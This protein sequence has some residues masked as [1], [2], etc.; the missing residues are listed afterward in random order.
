MDVAHRRQCNRR[1]PV[2]SFLSDSNRLVLHRPAQEAREERL[3]KTIV[4]ET[5]KGNVLE[6]L[7]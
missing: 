1:I 2:Q 5:E 7:V 6:T 3:H 4:V